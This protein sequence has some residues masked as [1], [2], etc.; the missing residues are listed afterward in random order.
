MRADAPVFIPGQFI[1]SS[2][3]ISL[4]TSINTI[5]S[6]SE[7]NQNQEIQGQYN[8]NNNN[9][10]SDYCL[11][12]TRNR[13][14]STAILRGGGRGRGRGQSRTTRK[15]DE[16][17]DD[18]AAALHEQGYSYRK[19]QPKQLKQLKQLKQP[20]G[21]RK[22][23]T[24][25]NPKR[26]KGQK[27]RQKDDDNNNNINI[28]I[29]ANEN[30][31]ENENTR[32]SNNKN[33]RNFNSARRRR[34]RRRGKNAH[35]HGKNNRNHNL[36]I[37]LSQEGNFN[38]DEKDNE[39]DDDDDDDDD[40]MIINDEKAFPSL[41]PT[42]AD[43]KK[44]INF[45]NDKNVD[46]NG[47]DSG[48][49]N[50]NGIDRDMD[51]DRDEKK[52]CNIA[53]TGHKN[54]V[55]RQLEL[56]RTREKMQ[57]ELDTFTRM[58]VL[59]NVRGG[60][61]E[62][63]DSPAAVDMPFAVK[64][65]AGSQDCDC[66][67]DCDCG[68]VKAISTSKKNSKNKLVGWTIKL[69]KAEKLKERWLRALQEK[70]QREEEKRVQKVKE[71]EVSDSSAERSS[72]HFIEGESVSSCSS[73][74]SNSSSSSGNSS[75]SSSSESTD[76]SFG[77]SDD[78]S[79][80]S[81]SYCL[82]MNEYLDKTYPLHFSIAKSDDAATRD[83]LALQPDLTARDKQVKIKVL[84]EMAGETL[85]LPPL[86]EEIS[87]SILH[88]AVL[89]NRPN[90]VRVLLSCGKRYGLDYVTS[91]LAIDD[92][93]NDLKCTTLMMACEFDFDACVKVLMSYGPRMNIRHPRSGDCALHIACRYGRAST[94]QALLSS[95]KNNSNAHHRLFCKRNRKGQTPLHL[96]C[97][98]GRI[99]LVEVVLS[100][101]GS[102]SAKVLIMEDENGYTPIMSAI[103]AGESDI[104]LY[105]LS[106]HSNLRSSQLLPKKC[107]ILA[108]RVKSV[109]IVSLL[110]DCLD[111]VTGSYDFSD[112]LCI[113]D[114]LC[115]ALSLYHDTSEEGIEIIRVLVQAG[116][117][118][119]SSCS[120]LLVESNGGNSVICNSPLSIA[121]IEGKFRFVACMLDTFFALQK[122]KQKERRMD[123][124]LIKRPEE[125]FLAK[126]TIENK[127][128]MKLGQDAIL[129][130]LKLCLGCGGTTKNFQCCLAIMRRGISLDKSNL[131]QLTKKESGNRHKAHLDT[132]LSNRDLEFQSSY[133]HLLQKSY[134]PKRRRNPYS[135]SYA[136]H[137]STALQK[138]EWIWRDVK[139]GEVS[140]PWLL[141]EKGIQYSNIK[142]E[143]DDECYIVVGT[144]RPT[145]FLAHKS[146]LSKKSSKIE[147]ALRFA[148]MNRMQNEF[149]RTEI[150]LDTSIDM[151]KFFIQHCYH[152][153]ISVG[154]SSN[155]VI[156]CQQLIDLFTL[157]HEYICPSLSLECEMR[158]L[159][160]DPY[161]CVCWHCCD[162]LDVDYN[163]LTLQATYTMKG[164][165]KL[166]TAE[167]LMGVIVQLE[168]LSVLGSCYDITAIESHFEPL[169]AL[170]LVAWVSA[171]L[172]FTDVLKSD[173]YLSILHST[174][175]EYGKQEFS[176]Q[177]ECFGDEI[178]VLFLQ[179]CIDAIFTGTC[180]ALL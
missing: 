22:V 3:P 78:D 68:K 85:T 99:D 29:A 74:S 53:N 28:H 165:S 104:V 87:L 88:F 149:E 159:S 109:D 82:P 130:T 6:T 33:D 175:R 129:N 89:L 153:S 8:N 81:D 86:S 155:K 49:R 118:P 111:P 93:K 158:L 136:C 180:Q 39:K 25:T 61:G 65:A 9:N 163:E 38:Y 156:C 11:E 84:R 31:N 57:Y 1:S 55:E 150:V 60:A 54:S 37:R 96:C 174:L 2:Q 110:V 59:R 167:N 40:V 58:E 133:I 154:L 32:T 52:W 112:Y 127:Q 51:M 152:G 50:G 124:L 121:C 141:A 71:K 23:Q 101:S 177:L 5:C 115:E 98:L 176:G 108:V 64:E 30:E 16:E 72:R 24:K 173:S 48:S 42:N 62:N 27:Q 122:K 148:E 137:W 91:A 20:N 178:A 166:L 7:S 119:F 92:T 179:T 26:N 126:E 168:D 117:N 144:V 79:T 142:A 69:L 139:D 21:R 73:S 76:D 157:G 172:Q 12:S 125:Y 138:M 45:G 44:E 106:W 102:G 132:V 146:I 97:S 77:D 63:V 15:N 67:R 100:Y 4:S 162:K 120:H 169:E 134:I 47:K 147:A 171:V 80:S 113:S 114:A 145:K 14:N 19:Q 140:C 35:E 43:K 90:I 17:T 123:R 13:S 128:C 70:E 135:R 75:V 18:A 151:M 105:L 34:G 170:R 143:I 94:V 103:A 46:T 164:P 131:V 66:D 107:L 161:R 160:N 83:L 10:N 41:G 56:Q 116:S 95:S 36:Q